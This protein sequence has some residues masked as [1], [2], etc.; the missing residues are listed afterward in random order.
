MSSAAEPPLL[1]RSQT[2]ANA[3]RAAC[4]VPLPT[5]TLGLVVH[6]QLLEARPQLGRPGTQR[7]GRRGRCCE[8]R[9]RGTVGEPIGLARALSRPCAATTAETHVRHVS[10]SSPRAPRTPSPSGCRSNGG[11][12]RPSWTRAW[13]LK[14]RGGSASSDQDHRSLEPA[15]N[16]AITVLAWPT[17][18]EG[19]LIVLPRPVPSSGHLGFVHRPLRM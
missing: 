17:S 8:R 7:D 15:R 6:P 19:G 9:E 12:W 2:I 13:T 14:A 10:P 18:D 3:S 11:T 4:H 16:I 5:L 1:V